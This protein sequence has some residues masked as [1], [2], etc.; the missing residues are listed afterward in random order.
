VGVPSVYTRLYMR[1]HALL[2]SRTEAC[3][4]AMLYHVAYQAWVRYGLS[5]YDIQ[6]K[7]MTCDFEPAITNALNKFMISLGRE[8]LH[9]QRC[10]MH[11]CSS[12]MKAIVFFGMKGD[13]IDED[14]GIK[15]FVSKL[16]ALPFA[17][18]AAIRD[19][20]AWMKLH[21]V[22]PL[23]RAYVPFQ[24]FCAYFERYW[25]KSDAFIHEWNVFNRS[26]R[27]KRTNNDLEG[28]HRYYAKF[29][30]IHADL[31][32]YLGKLKDLQRNKKIEENGQRLGGNNPTK[33]SAKVK[34]KENSLQ[35]LKDNFEANPRVSLMTVYK[36]VTSVSFLMRDYYRSA[37]PSAHAE[38][39]ED[40]QL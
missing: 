8:K 6:W 4:R 3:Y 22:S 2:P 12:L 18:P 30:G 25:L 24:Q 31:W 38:P 36:Y 29:F 15:H 17:P 40:D 26:R 27:A 20:Y 7:S 13:Y 34:R 14:S 19:V 5:P 33:Q 9:I 11:Y 23:L 10:H 39:D 32:T 28:N 21:K 37:H 35:T 16:F 1:M